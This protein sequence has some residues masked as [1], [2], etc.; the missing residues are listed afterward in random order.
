VHLSLPLETTSGILNVV[1]GQFN[2]RHFS[3]LSLAQRDEPPG[4]IDTD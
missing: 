3:D 4:D 1:L 2:L